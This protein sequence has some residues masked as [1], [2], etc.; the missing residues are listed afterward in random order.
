MGSAPAH[1]GQLATG[2]G[3]SNDRRGII[4]KH[5]RHRRQVADIAID[6]AVQRDDG[7]LVGCDAVEVAHGSPRRT[8]FLHSASV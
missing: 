8:C 1:H 7:G 4:R 6:D 3:V 2:A 5:A